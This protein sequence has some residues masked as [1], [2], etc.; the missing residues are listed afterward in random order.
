MRTNR[1][2]LSFEDILLERI[3]NKKNFSVSTESRFGSTTDE[4]F[5][6]DFKNNFVYLDY[7]CT[8]G[9]KKEWTHEAREFQT[10][11]I[12]SNEDSVKLRVKLIPISSPE[13]SEKEIRFDFFST[14]FVKKIA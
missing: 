9:N 13:V 7:S 1:E 6:F 4:I 2:E 8:N 11:S 5:S 10:I 14:G 3:R 12:C